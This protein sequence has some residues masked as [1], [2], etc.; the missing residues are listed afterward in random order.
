MG[1]NG[2]LD[3][4]N[5]LEFGNNLLRYQHKLIT[6]GQ[7]AQNL[8][9]TVPTLEKH[10]ETWYLRMQLLLQSGQIQWVEPKNNGGKHDE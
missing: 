10:F 8:G 5:I 6:K 2:K 3:K 7:F 4:V 9:I 1:A